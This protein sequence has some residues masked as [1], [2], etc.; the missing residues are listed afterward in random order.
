MVMLVLD[1]KEAEVTS[2]SS[3]SYVVRDPVQSTLPK[4]V[5]P[6]YAVMVHAVKASKPLFIKRTEMLTGEPPQ[7]TVSPV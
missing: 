6:S 2:T 3:N 4:G 7:V 5:A 1:V